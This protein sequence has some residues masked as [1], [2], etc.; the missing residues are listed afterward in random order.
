MATS[1]IFDSFTID[2]DRKLE[3]LLKER[4]DKDKRKTPKIDIDE[5]LKRGRKLLENL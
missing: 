2:S 1:S 5:K 4:N 3:I